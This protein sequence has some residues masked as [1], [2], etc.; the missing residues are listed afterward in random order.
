MSLTSFLLDTSN[1]N[2]FE[3]DCFTITLPNSFVIRSTSHGADLII[4]GHTYY[5]AKFGKWERGSVTFERNSPN[6]MDL[7][8]GCDKDILFPYS[9][10]TPLFQRSKL[11]ARAKVAV[12]DA[13]LDPN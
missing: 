12:T 13:Y 2:F 8:T 1:S 3:A 6:E 10:S 9:L 11:F 7:T 5:A 4:G